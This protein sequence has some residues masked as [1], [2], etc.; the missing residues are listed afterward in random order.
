MTRIVD[1]V[2]DVATNPG[3]FTLLEPSRMLV[4]KSALAVTTPLLLRNKPSQG[5]PVLVLTGAL[6]TN[7]GTAQM[8]R[9]LTRLGHYPH[10]PPTTTMFRSPAT[11]LRAIMSE[12]E[13]LSDQ[14]GEPITLAGWCM[15]G[16]FARVTAQRMPQRVRQVVNMGSSRT[17]PWYPSE[18][19]SAADPLPVPST[20]IYSRT[21]GM[22]FWK[23]VRE[24]D[25]PQVE[26][27]EIVSSHWGM[28]SHPHSLTVLADR[29]AQP[30]GTWA[31]YQGLSAARHAAQPP[32]RVAVA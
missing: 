12:T 26:N 28:A 18:L 6:S 10:T 25:G 2:V 15:S 21:D 24:P 31:P 30:L 1:R 32:A 14:Y 17:A 5:R 29:L 11:M 3:L 23:H 16:A 20:V 8:R 4:E 19:D 9:V 22:T 7:A 27:I 13:K